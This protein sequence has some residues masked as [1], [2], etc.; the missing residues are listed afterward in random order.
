MSSQSIPWWTPTLTGDEAQRIGEVL[1]S[2]FVNDGPVTAEFERA[3]AQLV[4]VRYAVAVT[5][6]TAA[7]FLALKACGISEGDEVLVP[8]LTFIATANAV[9]MAGATPVLVD[10]DSHGLGLDP[11][12]AEQAITPRTR[13]MIPV[14]ISGRGAL[15]DE[16]LKL[17]KAHDLIVIEDAAEALGS[18]IAAGPLGGLG[19]LGCFS[20]SPNKTITT[21]QGG[22]VVTNDAAMHAKLLRLKDQGRQQRGTGGAD[23]HQDVGFNFKFTDIQAAMGLAQLQAFP[24]R[25]D[26]LRHIYNLYHRYLGD[27]D[28]VRLPG[29]AVQQGE[30]PQ[31]VDIIIPGQRDKLKDSLQQQHIACREFWLPLH[32]QPPYRGKSQR[33]PVSDEISRDGMWLPSALQLGDAEIEVVCDCIRQWYK[34]NG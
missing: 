34:N 17:A 20:F 5:S 19:H 32:T 31:W 18:S 13:A 2:G 27:L 16:L 33:F 30:C 15:M 6:G 9:V 7:L 10:I 11:V 1:A 28:S 24:A 8:D 21:G 12:A 26:K 22:M 23:Q 29:F 4:G 14:H 25:I 3:I